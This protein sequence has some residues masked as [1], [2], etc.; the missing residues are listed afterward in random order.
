MLRPVY[1]VQGTMDLSIRQR[2][3][4]VTSSSQAKADDLDSYRVSASSVD[5]LLIEV[6]KPRS[7]PIPHQDKLGMYVLLKH[8]HGLALGAV[9]D[10]HGAFPHSPVLDVGSSGTCRD[11]DRHREWLPPAVVE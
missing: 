1:M 2:V 6:P 5:A 9:S 10:V 11:V 4:R 8:T 7:S 3:L